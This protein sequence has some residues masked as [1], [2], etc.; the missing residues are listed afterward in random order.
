VG[1][2]YHLSRDTTWGLADEIQDSSELDVRERS[3]LWLYQSPA[4][5]SAA[6]APSAWDWLHQVDL[7]LPAEDSVRPR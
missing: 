6:P 5:P 1:P 7:T 4:A 2:G 3:R